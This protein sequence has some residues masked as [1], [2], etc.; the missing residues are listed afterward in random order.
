MLGLAVEVQFHGTVG[1]DANLF[2]NV[3]RY[4]RGF[5]FGV[6]DLEVNRYSRDALPAEFTLDLPAQTVTGQVSWGEAIYFRDL[7]D[8]NYES[9]WDFVPSSGRRAQAHVPVRDLRAPRLLGRAD[10]QVS[11]LARR[12]ADCAPSSW[13]CWPPSRRVRTRRTRACSV[14]SPT[15]LATA[16][17]R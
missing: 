8:P 13:T 5:G 10:S 1:S 3:D 16:S 7:G 9:M 4:L 14:A 17:H 6:F 12:R 11:R 2:S 15:R